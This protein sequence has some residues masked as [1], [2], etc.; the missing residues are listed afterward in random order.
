M[1]TEFPPYPNEVPSLTSDKYHFFNA[2]KSM[3]NYMADTDGNVVLDLFPTG[4]P[5]GFNHGS[6]VNARDSDIYDQFIKNPQANGAFPFAEWPDMLRET[7]LPCAPKGLTDVILFDNA[8]MANDAAIRAALLKFKHEHGANAV[9]FANFDISDFN[10]DSKLMANE[11]C[12]LG[13]EHSYHGDYISTLSASH[14]A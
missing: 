5:L 14:D 12:V 6:L 13:F 11:L 9:D 10:S 4:N 3:G 1:T 7:M 8:S 2:K